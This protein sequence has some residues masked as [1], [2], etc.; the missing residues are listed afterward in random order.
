MV[1]CGF[2]QELEGDES[3]GTEGTEGELL[4]TGDCS[5]ADDLCASQD[6]IHHCEADSGEL[7]LFD[8][9]GLCGTS[10]NLSCIATGGGSHG[11]WCVSPGAQKLDSC[12]Q[13]EACLTGC[14]GDLLGG[15]GENCFSRTDAVT[16]RLYGS[17]VYCAEQA[18][19][20]HCLAYPDDCGNCIVAARDGLYGDC[21]VARSICNNDPS[22]LE[23]PWPWP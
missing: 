14:G 5:M 18:C 23:E 17:L 20:E 16:V 15:C 21:S 1:G 6:T 19:H 4:E 12:S 3:E 8:C 2:F 13:L 11:C 22:G 10:T 9:A 7:H